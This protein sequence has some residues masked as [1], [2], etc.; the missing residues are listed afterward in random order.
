MDK[1]RVKGAVDE[2]VGS[3]KQKVGELGGDSQLQVEG[4]V[5]N[6]KGNV[7]S[8]WGKAKDASREANAENDA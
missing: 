5:Q 7:E 8:A 3:T 2:V 1:D 4:T 6:V